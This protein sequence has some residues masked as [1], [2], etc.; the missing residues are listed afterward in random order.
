[1]RYIAGHDL[2]AELRHHGQ[3]APRRLARL[4]GQLRAALDAAHQAGLVHRDV[5]PANVLLSGT[6]PDEHAYLT[7]FG[8]T[9]DA[10][11]DSG[12]TGTGEWIGTI[13][14]AAPE[15]IEAGRLDGATAAKLHGHLSLDPPRATPL[16]SALPIDVDAVLARGMAKEPRD[17]YGSAGDLARELTAAVTGEPNT[18]PARTVATGRALTG[19]RCV[20]DPAPTVPLLR[21]VVA[22]RTPRP[23]RMTTPLSPHARGEPPRRSPWGRAGAVATAVLLLAITAGATTVLTGGSNTDAPTT[24]GPPPTVPASSSVRTETVER[25]VTAPTATTSSPT[26]PTATAPPP[27]AASQPPRVQ[28]IRERRFTTGQDAGQTTLAAACAVAAGELRCWTPNDG[29]TVR[30]PRVGEG[31]RLRT[32]E[33]R[34]RGRQPA[35]AA[36]GFGERW[37]AGGFSC[38]SRKSGL[39]CSNVEGHGWTL[40]RYQ[41]LPA[42]F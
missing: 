41:G 15:Q 1:M 24:A 14:Y 28:A 21:T 32:D 11:S 27:S 5:K 13:D 6:G 42:Y 30:L 37:S 12:L 20:G 19:V 25:T 3:L 29:F 16:A 34:N 18:E 7:D 31:F 4:L 8:L 23:R 36:L 17:R 22:P 39:T 2:A 35:Y 10:N 38:V 26:A 9:R 33:V 40:P